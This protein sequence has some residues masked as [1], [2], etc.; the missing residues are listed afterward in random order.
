MW[1]QKKKLEGK[2]SQ[3]KIFRFSLSPA[4]MRIHKV[5][6]CTG[7]SI[8]VPDVAHNRFSLFPGPFLHNLC[9]TVFFCGHVDGSPYTR[10]VS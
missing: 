4:R 6:H 9:G 10:T 3:G 7:M 5:N 8:N 1:R 2:L